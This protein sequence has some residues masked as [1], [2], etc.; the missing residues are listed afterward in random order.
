M[1]K[2]KKSQQFVI[3]HFETH[4]KQNLPELLKCVIMQRPS[5]LPVSIQVITTDPSL[6]TII[7]TR[8]VAES[9]SPSC[10]QLMT[11]DA[12]RVDCQ[13][14]QGWAAMA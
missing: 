4:T 12:R 9:F 7:T 8:T 6:A 13:H 11:N 1:S 14:F 10:Y 2:Y 3:R 5:H